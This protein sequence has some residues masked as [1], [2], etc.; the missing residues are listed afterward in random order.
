MK[1]AGLPFLLTHILL[2]SR[3]F[4]IAHSWSLSWSG[5]DV[6]ISPQGGGA[7]LLVVSGQRDTHRLN[8]PRSVRNSKSCATRLRLAES[9]ST[10]SPEEEATPRVIEIESLS[11]SQIVELIEFS[12]LQSCLALSKGNTIE[13][14]QLF[15]IA[16]KIASKQE[17]SVIKIL[18]ALKENA[19]TV[20]TSST[21]RPLDVGEE[22]LR[23]T[24]IQAI[25]LM[26]AHLGDRSIQTN[27]IDAAVVNAYGP[28]LEDL[29]A[30][31][32]SGLG[33]NTE[34]F[35][36]RRKDILF[37]ENAQRG[38]NPLLI[39]QEPIDPIQFAIVS[40]TIKLL[41]YTALV[42]AEDRAPPPT[43]EPS[44]SRPENQDDPS[45]KSS[46]TTSQTSRG[47]NKSN[48]GGRGFGG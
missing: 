11:P 47:K 2:I 16:V 25:Y 46:A 14:V 18:G 22:T 13:P 4:Q 21:K 37:P 39:E 5:N 9:S 31:Q 15:I 43:V 20:T 34:T 6:T 30:I 45:K 36:E 8:P 33:L 44:L 42:D 23:S 32:R 28:I 3:T 38:Q 17:P 1:N 29:L 48:G 41:F 27:D 40:Q 35:V 7:G 10:S 19:S 26:L 24:W 12:F